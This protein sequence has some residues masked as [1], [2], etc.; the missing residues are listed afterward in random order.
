MTTTPEPLSRRSAGGIVLVWGA[1]VVIALVVGVLAPHASRAAWMPLGFAGCLMLAFVVQLRAG[2]S[3]GFI[4]RM[5]ISA[6]GALLAMG[7]VGTGFG[8]ASMFSM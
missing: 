6:L 5:A 3:D 8:L 4:Q 7:L 1:A 2:H